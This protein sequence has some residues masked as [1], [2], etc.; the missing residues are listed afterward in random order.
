MGA[1]LVCSRKLP[2]VRVLYM[3]VMK[4]EPVTLNDSYVEVAGYELEFDQFRFWSDTFRHM[5]MLRYQKGEEVQYMLNNTPETRTFEIEITGFD[6]PDILEG[7]WQ[8]GK[9][10]AINVENK[11]FGFEVETARVANYEDDTA[12]IVAETR[13]NPLS[14]A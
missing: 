6:I 13:W 7:L 4:R 12:T 10:F 2:I 3:Q 11:Y 1:I 5:D 8:S 9:R 14:V